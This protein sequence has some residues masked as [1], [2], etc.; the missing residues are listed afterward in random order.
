MNRRVFDRYRRIVA[1][2]CEPKPMNEQTQPALWLIWSNEHRGW[3]KPNQAGYTK[4]R[5]AAG[6][7]K[8]ELA[9]QIILNAN[10]YL[11][12]DTPNE[13]MCPDWDNEKEA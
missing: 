7:Y 9:R 13:T 11:D 1:E 3:W 8:F 4:N 10:R 5:I 6:R 12:S 2:A